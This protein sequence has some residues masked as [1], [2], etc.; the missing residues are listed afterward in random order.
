MCRQQLTVK[1]PVVFLTRDQANIFHFF[2]TETLAYFVAL[3][4]FGLQNSTQ[5]KCSSWVTWCAACVFFQRKVAEQMRLRW[6]KK[7]GDGKAC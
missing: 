7:Y 1:V 5:G 4:A 3:S 6:R 2:W